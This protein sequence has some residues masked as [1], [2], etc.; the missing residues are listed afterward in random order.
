LFGSYVIKYNWH[1]GGN[2]PML[3]NYLSSVSRLCQQAA[4]E[5]NSLRADF[6]A[7]ATQGL[8]NTNYWGSQILPLAYLAQRGIGAGFNA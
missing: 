1:T 3:S 4:Y 8:V 6:L 2:L 5:V 7:I